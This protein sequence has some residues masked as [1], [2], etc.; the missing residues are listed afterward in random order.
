[1]HNIRV[2]QEICDSLIRFRLYNYIK[3]KKLFPIYLFFLG[4]GGGEKLHQRVET[5]FY[6]QVLK[7]LKTPASYRVQNMLYTKQFFKG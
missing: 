2:N 3:G 5:K 7:I 1:M 4:G 6:N